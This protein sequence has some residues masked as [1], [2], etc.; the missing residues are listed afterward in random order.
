[1]FQL[2]FRINQSSNLTLI[3]KSILNFQSFKTF[4]RFKISILEIRSINQSI[5]PKPQSI[6]IS[7][8]QEHF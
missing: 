8:K 4:I 1:M 6:K 5:N 7:I 2:D 3:Q